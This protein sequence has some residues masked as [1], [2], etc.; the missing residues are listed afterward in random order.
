MVRIAARW[1]LVGGIEGVLYKVIVYDRLLPLL[2][3]PFDILVGFTIAAV[4]LIA[5]WKFLS[6]FLFD[7]LWI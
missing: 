7:N 2:P 1:L 3:S 4:V 5:D 6:E